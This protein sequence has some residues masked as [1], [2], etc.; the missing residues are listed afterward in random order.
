MT[1]V[2]GS[3]EDPF[4][5]RQSGKP[6]PTL[7]KGSSQGADITRNTISVTQTNDRTDLDGIHGEQQYSDVSQQATECIGESE[8][9]AAGSDGKLQGTSEGYDSMTQVYNFTNL[10]QRQEDDHATTT[11]VE[12]VDTPKDTEHL[13]VIVPTQREPPVACE[14][15]TPSGEATHADVPRM[16]QTSSP[17]ETSSRL[18]ERSDVRVNPNH[19]AVRANVANFVTLLCKV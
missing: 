6:H 17:K 11:N 5:Q 10:R 2:F 9:E 15:R 19:Q 18:T 4:M 14:P 16:P 1:V 8:K 13:D 12:I 3:I 7:L